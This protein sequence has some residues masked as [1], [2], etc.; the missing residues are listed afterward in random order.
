MISNKLKNNLSKMTRKKNQYG[1]S[2]LVLILGCAT[3]AVLLSISIAGTTSTASMF[4]SNNITHVVTGQ[5]S[6]IRARLL[7]CSTDYPTGN[8]GTGFRISFPAAVTEVNVSALNCPGNSLGLWNWSDGV[9]APPSISG[10]GSWRYINDASSLRISITSN[11]S[12]RA[13]L[14]P[15]I[16]N[17]LGVNASMSGSSPSVTLTW[18]IIN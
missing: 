7:Q 12:D 10:F 16:I 15:N 4:S 14:I 2:L 5:A 18:L 8:N 3:I 1:F 17:F 11:A 6:I 13:S 9:S